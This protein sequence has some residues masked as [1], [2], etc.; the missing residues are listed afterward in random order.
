MITYVNCVKK[1]AFMRLSKI[2][3]HFYFLY[4]YD[5]RYLFDKFICENTIK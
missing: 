4:L 3:I 2:K 5:Y 1:Y